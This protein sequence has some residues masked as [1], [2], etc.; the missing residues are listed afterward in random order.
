MAHTKKLISDLGIEENIT[1][2]PK[3]PRKHLMVFVKMSDVTVGELF[4]SWL[5]YCVVM[6]ALSMG[7]PFMHK[8]NDSD[9]NA[10]YPELYPVY[11]AASPQDVADNLEQIVKQ[12]E[13]A[14]EKGAKGREWYIK[15]G[16][17]RALAIIKKIIRQKEETLRA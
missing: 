7:T 2:F 15:Y 11:K 17:N 1:W 10:D 12:K 4:H 9:F 16:V 14:E 6:E 5:T 3:M 8:R 13:E